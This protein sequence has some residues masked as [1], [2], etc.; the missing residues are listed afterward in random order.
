MSEPTQTCQTCGRVEVV[1][2]DGRGFPPD[3][4]KRK[5]AKRCKADGHVSDPKYLVGMRF[6]PPGSSATGDVR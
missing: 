1:N 6:R 5:L 2:P 3:I 4:A